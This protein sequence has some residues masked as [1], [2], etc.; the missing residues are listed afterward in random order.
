MIVCLLEATSVNGQVELRETEQGDLP[1]FFEHQ[2]DPV[3]NVMAMFPPRERAAFMTHWSQM[4]ADDQVVKRTILFQ[5]QVAGS[6][7]CF[8]RSGE[9]LIG[10][11]LGRPFWGQGIASRAIAA[12]V[13]SISARPLH[14]HVAKQNVASIRVLEKCG[15]TVSGESRAAAATGGEVVDEYVYSLYE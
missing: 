10:Y 14:A 15:F 11:W 3:A 8:Q 4:L 5:N 1:E 9:R 12:F 13:A 6:V 2:Q 7:I